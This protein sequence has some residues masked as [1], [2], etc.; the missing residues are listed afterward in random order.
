MPSTHEI[1]APAAP[2]KPDDSKSESNRGE[3]IMVSGD[4]LRRFSD[5]VDV[6]EAFEPGDVVS[7]LHRLA[8]LVSQGYTVVGYLAYEA[9]SAFDEAMVTH[10][11][12][13]QP[14]L[15]FGVYGS[16]QETAVE[17]FG[18]SPDSSLSC[19]AALDEQAFTAKIDRIH[20]YI[21]AG[22]TYQVNFTFPLSLKYTEEAVPL[23]HRLCRGQDAAYQTYIDTGR[24][25]ILSMSP[26][27]FFKLDGTHLFTKPMKGTAKRGLT[28]ASDRLQADGLAGS[29]KD[30]AENI[31]IVDLLRNDMGRISETGTVKV[32]QQFEVERYPTLWQMTST[33][34]SQ[35]RVDVPEIFAALFPSGSV[36]GAPKIRTME[37]INEL[38]SGP[39]GV[40]CGAVG[41]WGPD[42]QAEFSVAIRTATV[43]GKTKSMT[44]PV[45][46]GIT[47]DSSA[48][49]EYGECLLKAK[50]LDAA[51]SSFDL[52]ESLLWDGDFFLLD[53]HL[54]RL[55]E[56]AAYFGYIFDE[57]HVR[58]ELDRAVTGLCV[59]PMK[60]RLLLSKR[61][62]V[63]IKAQAMEPL[64]VQ[65]ISLAQHPVDENDVFLYH[66][67]TNRG[68]YDT[69]LDGV[70]GM[71]DVLLWNSRG[72]ITES[73]RANVGVKLDGVWVT[74]P[75]E[76]G[77]LAGTYRAALIEDGTLR[78]QV[79]RV[80]D[81]K[82]AESVRLFNSVRTWI[83][84][85]WVNA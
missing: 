53:R 23:F 64:R 22:D 45:G 32:E 26:E 58:R 16:V 67:T 49:G 17:D 68:V 10:S 70:S 61:G 31:M 36:T 77:L 65:R 6:V 44:Y 74:P 85:E 43:D 79:V 9:A 71:D 24:Y 41:W 80:E 83:D 51:I 42:R 18:G 28:A 39:R 33:I 1:S 72:E 81:M 25:K 60:V 75:V 63:A 8:D 59:Q 54:A 56:S 84:T 7:A 4:R 37:I 50:V 15:W 48:D 14:L 76:S 82:R 40:Y 57:A 29:A 3:V 5:P 27:L 73:T 66:K 13:E 55:G 21:A 62:D 2:T 19:E 35:T 47:W 46:A 20:E 11:S 52:L 30:R 38:E 12:T 78:E 34:S 69:A